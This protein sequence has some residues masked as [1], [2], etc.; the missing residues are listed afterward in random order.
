MP[1]IVERAHN[2][3]TLPL[4]PKSKYLLRSDFSIH[5]FSNI[6]SLKLNLESSQTLFLSTEL[7]HVPG[8]SQLLF[9]VYEDYKD[10]DGFLYLK[11]AAESTFG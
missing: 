9:T 4:L 8:P 6:V 1:I 10:E 7:G 2:E 11:Y 3:R 5:Q